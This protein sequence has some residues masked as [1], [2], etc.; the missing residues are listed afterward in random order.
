MRPRRCTT[1]D[2]KWRSVGMPATQAPTLG[3]HQSPARCSSPIFRAVSRSERPQG[4]APLFAP[5]LRRVPLTYT[6]AAAQG[7]APLF[8]PVP[9]FPAPIPRPFPRGPAGAR[10]AFAAVLRLAGGGAFRRAAAIPSSVFSQRLMRPKYSA[11]SSVGRG[12]G[13]QSFR[14]CVKSGSPPSLPLPAILL[15]TSS[16]CSSGTS[17]RQCASFFRT[18]SKTACGP[19]WSPVSWCSSLATRGTILRIRM[20]LFSRTNLS[21][22]L[23][24]MV[25]P[26]PLGPYN[27]TRKGHPVSQPPHPSR[28]RRRHCRCGGHRRTLRGSLPVRTRSV[29]CVKRTNIFQ[30]DTPRR[31]WRGP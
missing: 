1:R 12:M 17:G 5:V 30:I 31:T 27:I 15:S 14:R 2:R 26:P 7:Q 4:Q 3:M 23:C 29:Q 10:R 8:A 13:H 28:R 16:T 9:P 24:F 6:W 22:C 25:V 21:A 18:P 19:G 11:L 20:A